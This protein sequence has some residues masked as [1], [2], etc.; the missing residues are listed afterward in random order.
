MLIAPMVI[1]EHI[2]MMKTLSLMFFFLFSSYGLG[3]E[4]PTPNHVDIERYIGKWYTI[5]SL[6]QFFTRGCIGQ[7]AE[8]EILTAQSISVKNTCLKEHGT[9]SIYGQAVV[10]NSQT[11][12]E[13][14]VTFNSFFTR[15]F[16][17]KGDYTIIKLDKDY[18]WVMVGS[19][20]LKSLW[21]LSRTT[22]MPT[23]TYDEYVALANSL[24]FNTKK[25]YVSTF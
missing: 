11:N 20:N 23:S 10:K 6:P 14:E 25:L 24:G 17:V 8:Y 19:H 13:L 15:L 22:S 3:A 5:A 16:R 9:K 21:I 1:Q 18:R 7:T 12:A 4:L 2:K